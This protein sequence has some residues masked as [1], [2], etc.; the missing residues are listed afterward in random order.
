M[1]ETTNNRNASKAD[2]ELK[3]LTQAGT[4]TD[5]SKP[6]EDTNV[7]EDGK[8][9]ILAERSRLWSLQFYCAPD[10]LQPLIDE[11]DHYAWILHDRDKDENGKVKKPHYHLLLAYTNARNG[12][13]LVNK[14]DKDKMGDD[15]TI[16]LQPLTSPHA[17]AL[18]LIHDTKKA[19]LEGKTTYDLEDVHC[20]DVPYWYEQ[21]YLKDDEPDEFIDDLLSQRLTARQMA[22][23]YGRDY[24]RNYRAYSSFVEEQEAIETARQRALARQRL[25]D[26]LFEYCDE[27][28]NNP[29]VG[30]VSVDVAHYLTDVYIPDLILSATAEEEGTCRVN[31]A[32][33]L[34]QQAMS[35]LRSR[36]REEEPDAWGDFI[37]G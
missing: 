17:M 37:D 33:R 32:L 27:L 13:S 6:L 7:D 30:N 25:T 31:L 1:A 20:D 23:K 12:H 4:I 14:V 8:A 15:T 24:V 2:K 16:N 26:E 34:M 35:T 21:R 36:L 18:Y 5:V 29:D 19:I 3:K 28:S 11:A 10:V 22:Y 9:Q